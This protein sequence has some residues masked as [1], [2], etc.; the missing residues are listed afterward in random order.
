MTMNIA[1]H[2]KQ[3]LIGLV[4]LSIALMGVVAAHDTQALTTLDD[5]ESGSLIRGETFAAVYYMGADGFR[6]VFPNSNTYFTWYDDFDEVK[7]ISDSDLATI[8]IGGNVTYKPGS[9]MVK[10]Q[11][12]PKTYAVDEGGV[13][14]HV[15][16]EELATAL[17][18]P[19]WNTMIHDISDGFF[20]NYSIGDAIE[21]ASDYNVDEVLA[22]VDSIN[23]D[24]GLEAPEEIKITSDGFEPIDVEIEAGQ[25]VKFINT[26]EEKH[27]VTAD[28]LSWGSGTMQPDGEYVNRF[29]EAGT[30]TFF[31]SYDSSN[32]GAIYVD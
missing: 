25:V 30:Y 5:I 22:A 21:D 6:Y 20:T 31:D 14:R 9:Y 19:S 12:D 4:A 15:G 2:L 11:S 27:S 10:I 13:L 26:D 24:K 32:T 18:G 16:S 23:D 7:F 29:D 28:D 8:Q 17:Y 1:S 3:F